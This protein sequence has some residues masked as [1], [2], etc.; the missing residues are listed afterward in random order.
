VSMPNPD[1]LLVATWANEERIAERNGAAEARH[2]A[3]EDFESARLR[4]GQQPSR[5]QS[6]MAWIKA[7]LTIGR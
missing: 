2:H 7:R 5:A 1:P 3:S 4:G 6:A